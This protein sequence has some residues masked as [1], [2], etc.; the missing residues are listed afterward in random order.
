MLLSW[1]F[2]PYVFLFIAPINDAGPKIKANDVGFNAGP[3]IVFIATLLFYVV[4]YQSLSRHSSVRVYRRLYCS[5]VAIFF[6]IFP[7]YALLTLLVYVATKLH[8]LMSSFFAVALSQQSC[9]VL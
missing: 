4:T 8:L 2:A 7:I 3:F 6:S 9:L 1:I 5:F